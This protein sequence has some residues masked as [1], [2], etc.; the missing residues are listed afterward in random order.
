MLI[1]DGTRIP[2]DTVRW[3]PDQTEWVTFAWDDLA[4][5]RQGIAGS[6]WVLPEG[7]QATDTRKAVT[8]EALDG[9]EYTSCNQA[10]LTG[11]DSGRHQITNRVTFGDGTSLDR[12]VTLIVADT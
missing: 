12:S 3:D 4:A 7:W 6:E 10:L 1:H 9:T 11:P 2:T 8:A 5:R